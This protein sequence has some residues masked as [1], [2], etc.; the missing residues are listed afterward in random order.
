MAAALGADPLAWATGGGEDYELL[1]TCEPAAL[2]RLQRGLADAFGSRLTPIG[3]VTAGA[4][5]RALDARA[6]AR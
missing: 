3:E 2:A 5:R 6:G 1:L 4:S